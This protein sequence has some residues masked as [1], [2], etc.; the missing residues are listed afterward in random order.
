MFGFFLFVFVAK[1]L[2][3]LHNFVF[4]IIMCLYFSVFDELLM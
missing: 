3:E 1:T 4:I 2:R